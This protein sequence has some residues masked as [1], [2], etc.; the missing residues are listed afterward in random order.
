MCE[1]D[2]AS[3]VLPFSVHFHLRTCN[4]QKQLAVQLSCLA[5][6]VPTCNMS[7]R[8]EHVCCAVE[9]VHDQL[10]D[11][12]DLMG[13]GLGGQRSD[14]VAEEGSAVTKDQPKDIGDVRSALVSMP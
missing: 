14:T 12:V 2:Q 13:I 5:C 4:P 11:C 1:Q 10:R 7:R 8:V 6:G 9:T 3:E